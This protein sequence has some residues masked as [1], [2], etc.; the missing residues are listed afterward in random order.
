MYVQSPKDRTQTKLI[1]RDTTLYTGDYLK[2]YIHPKSST[3]VY[4][5]HLDPDS[6]LTLLFPS[7]FQSFESQAYHGGRYFVP[8][9]KEWLKLDEH[10]GDEVF[11][12]LASS[13]RLSR[14]ES[15][16]TKYI[17]SKKEKKGLQPV[18][19]EI[20]SIRRSIIR[21]GGEV[22]RP[23]SIAANLRSPDGNVSAVAVNKS[24]MYAKAITIHH[25]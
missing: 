15:A 20:K 4:I 2:L 21:F 5:F 8:R 17:R 6:E 23:I 7:D 16:Y 1:R 11:T 13:K 9:E 12:I 18:L 25:R 19:D 14:L 22:M 24:G 10:V 3:C